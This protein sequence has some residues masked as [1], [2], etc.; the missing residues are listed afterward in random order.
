[1]AGA[2]KTTTT[3]PLPGGEYKSTTIQNDNVRNFSEQVS[4]DTTSRTFD[5]DNHTVATPG[6][7]A[8]QNSYELSTDSL[9]Y[10]FAV[11]RFTVNVNHTQV[12]SMQGAEFVSGESYG[13]FITTSTTDQG[14][15]L[16]VHNTE[17]NET[18]H[19]NTYGYDLLI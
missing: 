7:T 6:N 15:N 12:T 8:T 1:M 2:T 10:D 9:V 4:V 14:S 5:A 11:N 18:V 19:T 3:S 13:N 17:T 16:V